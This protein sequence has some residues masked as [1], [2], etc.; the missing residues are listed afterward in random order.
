MVALLAGLTLALLAVSDSAGR[1]ELIGGYEYGDPNYYGELPPVY[2]PVTVTQTVVP[3]T[4]VIV[5][6]CDK[7]GCYQMN[8]C[9][10][11]WDYQTEYGGCEVYA[12]WSQRMGY[13][14]AYAA[15]TRAF[16]HSGLVMRHSFSCELLHPARHAS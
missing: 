12:D 13:A 5:P 3:R 9:I 15:R 10:D 14:I 11:R 7:L 1:S 8:A 6:I 16:R 2:G 4:A